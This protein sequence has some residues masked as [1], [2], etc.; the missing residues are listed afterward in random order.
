MHHFWP[1]Q[2]FPFSALD[3]SK[4]DFGG[5]LALAQAGVIALP[6]FCK[7]AAG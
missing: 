5:M 6:F 7:P 3:T 4:I 1:R 2:T